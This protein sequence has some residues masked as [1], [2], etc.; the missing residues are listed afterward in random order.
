MGT[1]TYDWLSGL[2]LPMRLVDSDG[3]RVIVSR[4]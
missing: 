4:R 2:G 1:Q 3:R